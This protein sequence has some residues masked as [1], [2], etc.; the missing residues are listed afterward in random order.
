[1]TLAPADT[2]SNYGWRFIRAT[3]LSMIDGSLPGEHADE[4]CQL[5]HL[6]INLVEPA[7]AKASMA[8]RQ[9]T[10]TDS[11]TTSSNEE[12]VT[13]ATLSIVR[14][15]RAAIASSPTVLAA[16]TEH[17]AKLVVDILQY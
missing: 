5:A 1:M 7:C 4:S 6:P 3:N 15:V 8:S 2:H 9:T 12:G 11:S 16:M 10:P 17:D 14:R 13:S